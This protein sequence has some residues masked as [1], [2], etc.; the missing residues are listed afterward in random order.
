MTFGMTDWIL[1]LSCG[2]PKV[3]DARRRAEGALSAR[4]AEGALSARRAEGA[5]SARRGHDD[6]GARGYHAQ[7]S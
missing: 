1:T 5:L 2:R 3:V 7:K 6:V 4:R